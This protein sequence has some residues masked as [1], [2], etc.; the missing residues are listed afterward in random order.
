MTASIDRK[1]RV[2]WAGLV[3][4]AAA[5]GGCGQPLVSA[6]V[7]GTVTLDGTPLAGV[8]VA[9]FPQT[10]GVDPHLVGQGT[11]DGAGRYTL[12]GTGALPGAVVGS[13]R[14]IV[15]PAKTPRSPG[16]A[17]AA[18]GQADRQ[19]PAK[20]FSPK[21]SPVFVNVKAG[22]PQTINVTLT[23]AASSQRFSVGGTP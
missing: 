4:A 10:E 3:L 13:N 11:T 1:W 5:A 6:E 22:G 18:L 20:Y 14:V 16:A 9:F 15:R 19:I 7:N 23:S 2:A 12:G 17:A 21:S 8:T